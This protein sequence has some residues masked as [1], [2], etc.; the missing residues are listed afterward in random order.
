MSRLKSAGL[1]R[2]NLSNG[3]GF[4]EASPG[5]FAGV[6]GD[7]SRD[8]SGRGKRCE[9]VNEPS[10][11]AGVTAWS[12]KDS[13]G[14]KVGTERIRFSRNRQSASSPGWLARSIDTALDWVNAERAQRSGAKLRTSERL[15]A[16]IF[17]NEC[18]P[19]VRVMWSTLK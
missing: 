18:T 17:F 13:K 11:G 1:E 19:R 12:A 15:L 3:A 9:T 4:F 2:C 7:F 16:Y 10:H 6:A 8:A 5:I 14:V